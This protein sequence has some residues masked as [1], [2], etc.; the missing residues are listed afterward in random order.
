MDPSQPCSMT[1]KEDISGEIDTRVSLNVLLLQLY[2][3][4]KSVM[5]FWCSITSEEKE[6]ICKKQ[7]C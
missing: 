1:F 5:M 4:C 3:M 7:Y 2:T 6:H